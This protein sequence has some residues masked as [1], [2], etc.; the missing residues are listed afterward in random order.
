MRDCRVKERPSGKED[1][2]AGCPERGARGQREA[3][4]EHGPTLRALV[5]LD[6]IFGTR[7]LCR[8]E[9]VN[10]TCV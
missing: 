9:V 7:L 6:L 1:M 2:M 3:R 10:Y 4:G 5:D 8:A